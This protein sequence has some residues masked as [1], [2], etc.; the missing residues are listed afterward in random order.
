[1]IIVVKAMK[2]GK[3]MAALM[4]EHSERHMVKARELRGLVFVE[5]N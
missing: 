3:R 1:M 4:Q 2:A 5:E